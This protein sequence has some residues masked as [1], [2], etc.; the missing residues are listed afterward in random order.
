MEAHL[1]IEKGVMRPIASLVESSS[2][3]KT[4]AKISY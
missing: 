2:V 3:K 1:F 4:I